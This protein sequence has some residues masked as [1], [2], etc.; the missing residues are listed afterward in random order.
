MLLPENRMNRLCLSYKIL[1]I[2]DIDK[3]LHYIIESYNISKINPVDLKHKFYEL[4]YSDGYK[5]SH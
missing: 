1:N 4:Y 3:V 5:A 2:E